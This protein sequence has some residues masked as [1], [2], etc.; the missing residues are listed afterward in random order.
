M[1]NGVLLGLLAALCW[2][3]A[4]FTLR[5]AVLA[6]G[7]FRVLY[8]MQIFG[9]LT[10][11]IGV[12]PWYPLNFS[13]TTPTLAL[14]AS[15]LALVI[16]AGAALLY[17]SFAIGK[18][19]VVSPIAASFGAIVTILALIGGERPKAPQLLGLALLLVGVALSS[20]AST[21]S[22]PAA[23]STADGAPVK[24]GALLGP[25][26]IEALSAT[27]L[28]GV[29]YF[30]LR[31]VVASVGGVETAFIGKVADLLALTAMVL[32]GWASRRFARLPSFAQGA[33]I[34][35]ARS[36][37]PRS[38]V[39]WRW[40]VPGAVL[41]ISANVAYNIGVA[42]A[43]TSI[44]ATLSSLFT[45][46]TVVLAWIFLRERLGRLQWIGVAFV[47]VGIALVNL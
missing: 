42:G 43:L 28:F 35:A 7:T 9:I 13:H 24:R 14:A 22:A 33:V 39:F 12:A 31:G 4:D 1:V 20:I 47:L 19:A 23:P 41:D 15:G 29:A 3:V 27:A 25:G 46:V 10:L 21:P 32:V 17:R 30:A 18:L 38:A 5:G 2:G 45:A 6:A 8:F 26:V 34:P 16:L 37:A 11:L 40:I 36:L 44:V